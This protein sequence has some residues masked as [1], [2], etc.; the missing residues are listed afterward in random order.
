[1]LTTE[2][3]AHSLMAFCRE[4]KMLEAQTELMHPD[5]EQIEPKNAPAPSV[6]GLAAI[7]EKERAFI[8]N[9]E[10]THSITISEPLI[11]GRFFSIQMQFDMTFRG[12]GR[13]VIEELGV[14]EVREGKIVREQFF[15]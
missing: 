13:M 14:Y 2:A 9:V 7:Q 6:Q 5:C 3:I 4:G 8:A 15:Y 12:R 1:M 11:A 10:A